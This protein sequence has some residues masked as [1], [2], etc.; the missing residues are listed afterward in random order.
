V[1]AKKLRDLVY[2]SKELSR[3]VYEGFYVEIIPFLLQLRRFSLDIRDRTQK[4][5][6]T[7]NSLVSDLALKGQN[8]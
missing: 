8:T 4:K 3:D 5:I 6:H 2:N 7:F 1:A